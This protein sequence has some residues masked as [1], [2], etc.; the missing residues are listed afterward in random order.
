V[1]TVVSMARTGTPT[2]TTSSSHGA[3]TTSSTKKRPPLK[4]SVAAMTRR[5]TS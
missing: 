2:T 1:A 4:V 5:P 3:T